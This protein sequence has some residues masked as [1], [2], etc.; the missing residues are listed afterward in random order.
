MP[1][2]GHFKN[3]RSHKISRFEAIKIS[4]NSIHM[5]P[6][7]YLI[8]WNSLSSGNHFTNQCHIVAPNT[9]KIAII[10][11]ITCQLFMI[12][13]WCWRH[14]LKYNSLRNVCTQHRYL[15]LTA[16]E[17]VGYISISV[18]TYF[19]PLTKIHHMWLGVGHINVTKYIKNAFPE[20]TP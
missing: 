4:W 17:A 7:V 2:F 1:H 13:F 11:I 3:K 20:V 9:V 5:F 15:I 6:Y 18:R 8:E 10:H 14:F 12:S 16:A 19:L